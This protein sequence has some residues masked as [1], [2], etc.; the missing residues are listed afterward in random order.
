MLQ[1][2]EYG[3]GEL[4]YLSAKQPIASERLDGLRKIGPNP[5]QGR[6]ASLALKANMLIKAPNFRN[7]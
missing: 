6:V 7:K 5:A 3:S 2:E 4:L 1:T